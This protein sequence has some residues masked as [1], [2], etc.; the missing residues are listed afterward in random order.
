MLNGCTVFAPAWRSWPQPQCLTGAGAQCECHCDFM[1][2]GSVGGTKGVLV[3]RDGPLPQAVGSET[4]WVEQWSSVTVG[5]TEMV[6]ISVQIMSGQGWR[7]SVLAQWRGSGEMRGGGG[8]GVA[9][10]TSHRAHVE[11]LRCNDGFG[12]YSLL[13]RVCL[14]QAWRLP[15]CAYRTLKCRQPEQQLTCYHPFY[16]TLSD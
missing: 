7:E 10:G 12:G 15:N 11:W 1:I 13:S 16:H 6:Y 14:P 9:P 2:Q 8:I 4:E 5:L 3:P